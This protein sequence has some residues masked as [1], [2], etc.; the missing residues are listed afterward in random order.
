MR[1]LRE[2]IR[3]LEK[4]QSSK[5]KLPQ[6]KVRAM[7]LF[8]RLRRG[9]TVTDEEARYYFYQDD[10]YGQ[11]YLYDIKRD[12][13]ERLVNHLLCLPDDPADSKVLS[14]YRLCTK[15]V[16]LA[17]QLRASGG[18]RAAAVLAERTL[19]MAV[20][21]Q[22][23][24]LV[25]ALA[26]ML[27]A[28]YSMVDVREKEFEHYCDL[29]DQYHR[30][31]EA[32]ARLERLYG[33][34]SVAHTVSK[35]LGSK[36][37][38]LAEYSAE[39]RMLMQQH[40]KSYRVHL[41]GYS[42]LSYLAIFEGAYEEV[43]QVCQRARRYFDELPYPTPNA[44]FFTFNYRPI[45]SLIHLE[46][47]DAAAKN[48]HECLRLSRA[49]S[50]NWLVTRHY[51][52]I[53][54]FYAGQYEL[55][56]QALLDIKDYTIEGEALRELLLVDEAYVVFLQQCGYIDGAPPAFRLGKFLNEVP[57]FSK[58]KQ[59][60]NINILILQVLFPLV[61]GR[62]DDLVDRMDALAVY[63]HRYLREEEHFRSRCFFSLLLLLPKNGFRRA[64]IVQ[65]ATPLLEELQAAPMRADYDVEILPYERLWEVVMGVL[66][67]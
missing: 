57:Q 21:Y 1:L 49:G 18:G 67:G 8:R 54:G 27:I 11:R 16:A 50:H 25:L 58:D 2:L 23:S 61:Q 53:L 19:K 35:K 59:G 46:K 47:Y 38:Q 9:K 34:V 37:A 3:V 40:P 60:L 42:I 39:I 26:R 12:L 62:Y 15:Q 6:G 10:P 22:F 43:V 7:Q 20:K 66:T 41:L 52:M 63:Q 65:A 4:R 14:T 36:G 29:S 17:R 44:T 28:H 30:I 56:Y 45:P 13:Q 31:T 51:Q 33:Q 5:V 55:A 32:E 24:D 64:E 48:I